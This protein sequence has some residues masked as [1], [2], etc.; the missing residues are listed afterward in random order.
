MIL[1]SCGLLLTDSRSGSIKVLTTLVVS[2]AAMRVLTSWCNSSL[3]SKCWWSRP[4]GV[5]LQ[6]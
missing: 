6:D 5:K 4:K 2:K 3:L 1:E